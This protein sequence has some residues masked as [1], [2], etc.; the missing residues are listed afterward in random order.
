MCQQG[1][2]FTLALVEYALAYFMPIAN[3]D[4]FF[5]SQVMA[6]Y[7]MFLAS[8]NILDQIITIVFPKRNEGIK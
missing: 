6:V 7:I 3:E 2:P 4:D 8:Q 5:F 1:F